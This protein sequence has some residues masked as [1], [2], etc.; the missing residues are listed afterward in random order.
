MKGFQFTKTIK[1]S[2]SKKKRFMNNNIYTQPNY[3]P[4]Q[5][6]APPIIPPNSSYNQQE[7]GENLIRKNIGKTAT[8]YMSFS[9]SIQWRD[10]IFKGII[11]Q[12]GKDYVL[13]FDQE[14]NKRILLWNVYLDY[15][16]FDE[17]LNRE[18]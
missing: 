7:Y 18:Y 17:Q 13:I 16:V 12:A 5:G 4:S 10:S 6:T 15:I 9:D 3:I 8:F 11:E 2:E 14:N 1:L